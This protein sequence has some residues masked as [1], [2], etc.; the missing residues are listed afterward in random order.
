[1]AFKLA[2]P[3]PEPQVKISQDWAIRP[4][5]FK[6]IAGDYKVYISILQIGSIVFV[7][8]PADFSGELAIPLY[9]EARELGLNLIITSFNGGY[10]GYVIRDQWY[11]LNKY[12]AR[13]MSWYGPHNGSYLSEVV[14]RILKAL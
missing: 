2:L 13:A 9:K 1:M 4:Y 12:E 10:I 6:A 11:D 3:L 14:S 8:I 7:G 5:L